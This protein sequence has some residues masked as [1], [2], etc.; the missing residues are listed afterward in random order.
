MKLLNTLKIGITIFMVIISSI[1]VR[2]QLRYNGTNLVMN[3]GFADYMEPKTALFDKCDGFL[4]QKDSLSISLRLDMQPEHMPYMYS[5]TGKIKFYN[6]ED[7]MFN[8]ISCHNI[9]TVSDN[10]MKHNITDIQNILS[11]VSE[12]SLSHNADYKQCQNEQ[13]SK[14]EILFPDLVLTDDDGNKFVNY[15]EILPLLVKAVKELDSIVKAQETEIMELS[16]SINH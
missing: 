15:F 3:T 10:E 8:A 12:L 4:I 16:E 6:C 9:R 2:G 11:S 13:V 14:I 5:S 1:S 7:D